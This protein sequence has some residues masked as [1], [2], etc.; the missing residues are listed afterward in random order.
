MDGRGK[1]DGVFQL[2]LDLFTLNWQWCG[3]GQDRTQGFDLRGHG[4]ANLVDW[5]GWDW[6]FSLEQRPDNLW[7]ENATKRDEYKV[8]HIHLRLSNSSYLP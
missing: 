8:V 2:S 1:R 7:T 3:A 5:I 4:V 6:I